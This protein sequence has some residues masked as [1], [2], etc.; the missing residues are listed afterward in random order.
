MGF[1]DSSSSPSY[2]LY[3]CWVIYLAGDIMLL[4]LGITI[5]RPRYGLAATIVGIQALR[6]VTLIL[7]CGMTLSSRI[8]SSKKTG[9]EE[10]NS[11]LLSQ[12]SQAPDNPEGSQQPAE[13]N[14]YGSILPNQA[15][16]KSGNGNAEDDSSNGKDDGQDKNRSTV[17]YIKSFKVCLFGFSPAPRGNFVTPSFYSI[18]ILLC[19]ALMN[20]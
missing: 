20:Y 12:S 8:T 18:Q 2:P 7:L 10:E 11:P 4:S 13:G 14:G 1:S 3:G 19:L 9:D 15:K 6:I 17:E 16:P 5:T